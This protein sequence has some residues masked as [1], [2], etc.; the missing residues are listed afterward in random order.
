MF[1]WAPKR[2][3]FHKSCLPRKGLTIQFMFNWAGRSGMTKLIAYRLGKKI[4][5]DPITYSSLIG[6]IWSLISFKYIPFSLYF[7]YV[8][9]NQQTLNLL[10]LKWA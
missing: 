10:V 3:P 8:K 9:S 2:L 4:T 7:H 6:I 1:N 5:R